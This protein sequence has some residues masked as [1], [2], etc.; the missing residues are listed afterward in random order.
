MSTISDTFDNMDFGTP[1]PII[2]SDAK[3]SDDKSN[4]A[5]ST[6]GSG[7]SDHESNYAMSTD[8]SG[9]SDH[10]GLDSQIGTTSPPCYN[11]RKR[12]HHEH[13]VDTST[14]SPTKKARLHVQ[15]SIRKAIEKEGKPSGLLQYFK[16]ATEAEH[17]A[18]LDRTTA[19]VREN[20]E[21]EQWKKDQYER[22]LQVKKRQHAKERKQKQ[23]EREMKR[24]VSCGLRSPGGTKK[25]VNIITLTWQ[26]RDLQGTMSNMLR[27]RRRN[28]WK[29]G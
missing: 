24:Q 18:Y 22:V 14:S 8:G 20:A 12:T 7:D 19:E 25:K 15:S 21:N 2:I 9:D 27:L 16:K 5:M 10:G 17:Q 1:S 6:D 28:R 29:F 3:N 23:Q 26:K 11:M 4:Y 13:T